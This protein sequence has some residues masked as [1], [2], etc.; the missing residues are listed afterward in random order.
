MKDIQ[1]IHRNAMELVRKADQALLDGDQRVFRRNM[2]SAYLLEKEAAEELTSSPGS[3]PT[4]G[5]LFRSA[6]TLA[7][8]IGKFREAENF[9]ETALSGNPFPEIRSELMALQVKVRTSL[10]G[11]AGLRRRP[12]ND[13]QSIAREPEAVYETAQEYGLLNNLLRGDADG[14]GLLQ[15]HYGEELLVYINAWG[16]IRDYVAAEDILSATFALFLGGYKNFDLVFVREV[17][18]LLYLVARIQVLNYLHKI[19]RK[20]LFSSQITGNYDGVLSVQGNRYEF[21]GEINDLNS[22]TL[23]LI[24]LLL[25][26]R[27]MEQIAY[28]MRLRVDDVLAFRREAFDFIKEKK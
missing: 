3:E 20:P 6:A 9:I 25:E 4:R 13:Y 17:R 10:K 8:N 26:G 2:E 27:N 23:E 21:Y 11:I 28:E 18:R 14:S 15:Q 5:V 19:R 22:T 16:Y 12:G 24:R 1:Q 7:F